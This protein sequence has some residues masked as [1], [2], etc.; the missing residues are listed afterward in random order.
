MGGVARAVAQAIATPRAARMAV[1]VLFI[2][3]S[4]PRMR[5][6]VGRFGPLVKTHHLPDI[7]S[8]A[9]SRTGIDAALQ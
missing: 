9:V 3:F 4:P 7:D 8:F 6:R 2:V 5:A 1:V